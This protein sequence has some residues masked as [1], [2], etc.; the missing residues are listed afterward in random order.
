MAGGWRLTEM[1]G[2]RRQTAHL[3]DGFR[4][5]TIRN[6]KMWTK[7]DGR[8]DGRKSVCRG[9]LYTVTVV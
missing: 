9:L 6:I 7:V 8:I 5:R 3:K 2:E 1:D 4:R